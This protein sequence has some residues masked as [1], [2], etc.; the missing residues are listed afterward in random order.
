MPNTHRRRRR[1]ETVELRRVGGVNTPV[2][3]RD[4]VYIFLC[5]QVTTYDVIVEKVIKKI[6]EY[7]TT[8]TQQIR[9]F[10]NMQRHMLG[11]ILLL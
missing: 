10:T 3:S 6:H 5:S 11:H 4:P 8:V 2:G 1:N 9:M 7:Y